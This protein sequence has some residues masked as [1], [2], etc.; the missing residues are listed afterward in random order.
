M[1]LKQINCNL[2]KIYKMIEN[3]Q[4]KMV[5]A[6]ISINFEDENIL[7]GVQ[8]IQDQIK[9]SGANV[10][11]VNP[12][13]LHI[14]MEFLGEISEEQITILSEMLSEIEFESLKLKVKGP[15]VLPN[16]KHV[17]VVY[18]EI[19]GEIEKL[20]EIQKKIRNKL[21]NKGFKVDSRPFK[22]HLT[23]GRVKSPKNKDE[24]IKVIKNLSEYS[25]GVQEINSIQLKKSE[26]KT[27]GPEYTV[28]YKVDALDKR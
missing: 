17:R 10:R 27:E 26:L 7:K 9:N 15:G 20:K 4:L 24:L 13:I 14:T 28:L 3:C 19:N 12:E 1:L 2:V 8:E 6:F 16:E 23:I 21:R 22:P 25:C 11:L 5:R 18:C